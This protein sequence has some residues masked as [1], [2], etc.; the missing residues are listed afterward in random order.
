MLLM[1]EPDGAMWEANGTIW[2]QHGPQMGAIWEWCA[3]YGSQVCH[4][5]AGWSR[6]EPYG[7][8]WEVYA[9]ILELHAPN[10]TA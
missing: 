4:M 10:G 9:A 7:A 5:G 8:V 3:L 1:W 2:A 6:M